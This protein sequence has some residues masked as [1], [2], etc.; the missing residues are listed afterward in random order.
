MDAQKFGT[1][2]AKTR[3][4]CS[5]TQ[6][7][8]AEKLRV[9]DKAVSRWERG[10]G[11][12]DINTLEP[13]AEALGVSVLEL[14]KSE[15]IA[16]PEIHCEEAAVALS[17]TIK[18]ADRQ[19]LEERSQERKLIAIAIGVITVLSMFLLMMDNIGWSVSNILFTGIGVVLPVLC[20]VLFAGLTVIGIIRCAMGKSCKQIFLVALGFAVI[21]VIMTIVIFLLGITAFPGQQ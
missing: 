3:K 4:E 18:E 9:T 5:M 16:A 1:F 21:I 20:I 8:L 14:V 15:R 10:L 11:F 2:I 13:L 12:P 17:D 6:A 19:R 7:E